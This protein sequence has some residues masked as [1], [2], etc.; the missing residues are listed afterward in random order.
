MYQNIHAG[1][2]SEGAC[3]GLAE[4]MFYFVSFRNP[5]FNELLCFR[6]KNSIF[7]ATFISLDFNIDIDNWYRCD[8]SLIS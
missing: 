2:K 7:R 6:E 1:A 3:G 5:V 4:S 8:N